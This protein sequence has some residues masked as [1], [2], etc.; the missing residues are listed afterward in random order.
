MVWRQAVQLAEFGVRVLLTLPFV[1]IETSLRRLAE[2]IEAEPEIGHKRIVSVLQ[3]AMSLKLLP[4]L[5]EKVQPAF[6]LLFATNEVKQA[7]YEKNW[8]EAENLIRISGEK[9]GMRTMNQSL[10]NLMLKRKIDLK[11]GFATSPRPDE[12]DRMLE[13]VGF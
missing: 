11:A 8:N 7:L 6:E 13:K 5:D 12:L 4:G 2:K 10:M 1:D 9:T 3:I